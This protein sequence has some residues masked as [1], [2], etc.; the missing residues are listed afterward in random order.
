MLARVG[1]T[2]A[3]NNTALPSGGEVTASWL[4]IPPVE[5]FRDSWELIQ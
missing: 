4:C 2:H 5:I 3:R 1:G